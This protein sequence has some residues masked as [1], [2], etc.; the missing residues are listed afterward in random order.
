MDIERRMEYAIRLAD[1]E[2]Q[3]GSEDVFRLASLVD[4]IAKCHGHEV[5]VDE[6]LAHEFQVALKVAYRS[7]GA[8]RQEIERF[9]DAKRLIAG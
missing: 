6:K 4:E 5:V 9:P 1:P 8:L 7:S 2:F 3:G